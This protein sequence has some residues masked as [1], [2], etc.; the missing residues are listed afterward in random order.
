MIRKDDEVFQT[1]RIKIS[2]FVEMVG[3]KGKANY[4]EIKKLTYRLLERVIVFKEDDGDRQTHWV[5][6][7]KYHDSKGFVELSFDP[8]LMPLLLQMKE[9]FTKYQSQRGNSTKKL[10]F[11]PNIRTT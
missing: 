6:S 1:C 2:D 11:Y 4:N 5:S 10:L 3:L 7:A 8:K 9:F